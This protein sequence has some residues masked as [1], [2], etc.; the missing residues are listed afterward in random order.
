VVDNSKIHKA[1]AIEDWSAHHPRVTLLF[2]PTY[3]PRA[4]PIELAFGEVHDLSTRMHTRKRVPALVADVEDHLERNGPWKYK[5]SDLY[6][7]PAVTAA[8]EN[9]AAEEH[10]QGAA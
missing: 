2:V 3:C 1:K 10:S 4:K 7:E 9:I 5:L 8:L 6:Y